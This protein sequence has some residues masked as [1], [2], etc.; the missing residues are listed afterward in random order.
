MLETQI[1]FDKQ[2]YTAVSVTFSY[3]PQ[4]NNDKFYS[5]KYESGGLREID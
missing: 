2:K 3:F 4:C 5:Y 1:V